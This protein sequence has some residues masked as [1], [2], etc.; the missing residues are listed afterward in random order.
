MDT[1]LVDADKIFL[2]GREATVFYNFDEEVRSEGKVEKLK[3]LFGARAVDCRA[4]PDPG[5]C[6]GSC[7]IARC[8]RPLRP[9]A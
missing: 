6:D 8:R 9:K 7:R 3:E 4:Q 2:A 1:F 5:F